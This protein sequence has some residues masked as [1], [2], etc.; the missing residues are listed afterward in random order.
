MQHGRTGW[1]SAAVTA[2]LVSCA[3][4]GGCNTFPLSS[5]AT[6]ASQGAPVARAAGPQQGTGLAQVGATMG[7]LQPRTE[8]IWAIEAGEPRSRMGGPAT[9]G[10][11]G[12][13]AL[14][15]YGTFQVAGLSVDQARVRIE[16]QLARQVRNPKVEL[17]LVE[18][19]HAADWGVAAS[20]AQPSQPQAAPQGVK[21]T[22][23]PVQRDGT[24]PAAPTIP[25]RN[26]DFGVSTTPPPHTAGWQPVGAF[27]AQRGGE[28]GPEL[29]PPPRSINPPPD[30]IVGPP[31]GV[32]PP[33]GM[34]PH[35]LPPGVG[36][37]GPQVGP[38]VD[39]HAGP[40]MAAPMGAPMA[41]MMMPQTPFGRG[42]S[43]WEGKK[44]AL[45]PYVIAP[46]D[47]LQ[48][49]SL[50]QLYTQTI[51]GPHLVRPD[52][53]VGLGAYGSV[54]V[55]GMT[56][57]EARVAIAKALHTRFDPARRSLKDVLDGLSV[58]V[59]AYNSRVY[60]VITNR[61]GFGT[62]VD[63]LPV[64]GS[65]TV[66]DAISQIRGL[67]PEAAKRR[68]WVARK[69]PGHSGGD[70]ILP[71]D[72]VGITERGEMKTNYQLLPG[73]RVYVQAEAIQRADWWLSR[74]LSP[75]QRLFGATL[76]GSETV[77]SIR[78]GGVG[79]GGGGVGR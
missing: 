7:V 60:Y 3:A 35:G 49:D 71:V 56:I 74:W 36:P 51:R 1:V 77:N 19:T 4:T 29:A 43:P 72:W 2:V 61:L 79:G 73:D 37:L 62:I 17:R 22:W 40:P 31:P 42:H 58:D 30:A 6:E 24:W 75:I 53:T 54:F 44:L 59:L 63:R 50:E 13:V 76:L 21:S 25:S 47:I 14:G 27:G 20:P 48:I 41:P 68:I 11:D 26:N 46:P 65:E 38:P 70:N 18:I 8:V 69:T 57:D 39:M 15:P 34:G 28:T 10:P 5:L 32:G 16:R 64:T 55:A 9:V 78:N 45:P 66:L 67:P 23:R 33:L 12:T 52:G